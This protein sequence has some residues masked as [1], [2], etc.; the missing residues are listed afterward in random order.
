MDATMTRWFLLGLGAGVV[1]SALIDPRRGAARRAMIRDRTTSQ[2]HHA[3]ERARKKSHQLGWRARGILHETRG[4]L[5]HE[6]VDDEM[7]LK[8]KSMEVVLYHLL[9]NPREGTNLFAYVPRDRILVQADLYDATWLQHPWGANVLS[10]I[11][12]R[13][14]KVE[15]DVPVHGSIESFA[16]MVKTI[17]A[18]PAATS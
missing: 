18:K 15:K 8:D 9:D 4:R 13:K 1:A 12:R 7:T 10:N 2:V 17:K 6:L 11:E 5:S 3:S 16:D 14:L